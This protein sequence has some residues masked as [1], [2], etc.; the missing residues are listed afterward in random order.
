VRVSEEGGGEGAAE[1]WRGTQGY[2]LLALRQGKAAVAGGGPVL[3]LLAGSRGGT[4]GSLKK[5]HGT[6]K[7]TS[8]RKA[9]QIEEDEGRRGDGG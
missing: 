7:E 2:I 9:K 3:A 5:V 6:V 4:A 8:K 1:K